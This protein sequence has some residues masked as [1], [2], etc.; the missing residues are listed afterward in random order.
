VNVFSPIRGILLHWR[1]FQTTNASKGIESSSLKRILYY[2]TYDEQRCT[3]NLF[4][5]LGLLR[6]ARRSC[7]W[8]CSSSRIKKLG[9][10]TEQLT[11][12]PVSP[13]PGRLSSLHHILVYTKIE[14]RKKQ[15]PSLFPLLY[16]HKNC[17]VECIQNTGQWKTYVYN[18]YTICTKGKGRDPPCPRVTVSE[19]SKL[20]THVRYLYGTVYIDPEKQ[21]GEDIYPYLSSVSLF[22]W[23]GF[24]LFVVA[25][26][27]VCRIKISKVH[28]KDNQY[29]HPR[30]ESQQKW[31]KDYVIRKT[32]FQ[33]YNF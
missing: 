25:G 21:Q 24:F 31:F 4:S 18:I 9:N 15:G 6:I 3:S 11:Q 13:F 20:H 19:T 8:G 10:K 1:V 17:G 26:S 33:V 16:I 7:S 28:L 12:I 23:R 2:V 14:E 32:E 29:A 5:P 30:F 27:I 22:F